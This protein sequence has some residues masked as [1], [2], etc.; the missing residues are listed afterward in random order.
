MH[1]G[2]VIAQDS[3]SCDCNDYLYVNETRNGGRVH[4]YQVNSDGSLSEIL[5]SGNPWYPG[6]STSELSSPHGLGVDL[7]GGLYI[8]SGSKMDDEIRKLDCSGNIYDSDT[9]EIPNVGT[10]NICLLYTSPSPRDLST[11]RMPSSA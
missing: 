1:H 4:K 7:N 9:F 6:T 10:H 2:E 11:S 8:G 3:A 5:I